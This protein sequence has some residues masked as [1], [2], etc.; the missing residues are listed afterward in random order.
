MDRLRA[1]VLP[2]LVVAL[3][4]IPASGTTVGALAGASPGGRAILASA[5]WTSGTQLPALTATQTVSMKTVANNAANAIPVQD[6]SGRLVGDGSQLTGITVG[7]I[8]TADSWDVYWKASN[9]DPTSVDVDSVTAGTQSFAKSSTGSDNHALLTG[10]NAILGVECWRIDGGS[11]AA[12]LALQ[13][14]SGI[15][16]VGPWELRVRLYQPTLTTVTSSTGNYFR[17]E[18]P[19]GT[20]KVVRTVIASGGPALWNGSTAGIYYSTGAGSVGSGVDLNTGWVTYTLKGYAHP[21]SGASAAANMAVQLSV[22][23]VDYPPVISVG[24]ANVTNGSTPGEIRIGRTAGTALVY[25]AEIAYRRGH[26]S[27]LPSET[28]RGGGFDR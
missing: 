7:Q 13:I 6:S 14:D 8:G 15:R 17:F 10:G 19:F 3:A 18:V 21:A 16:T 25:V 24:N 11:G 23:E 26:N 4:V 9:G 28:F 22:G 2:L 27:R 12:A 20:S 5:S 1:F